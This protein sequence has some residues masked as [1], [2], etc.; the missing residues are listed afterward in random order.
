MKEKLHIYLRVSSRSQEVDGES[1]EFQKKLGIEKSTQLNMIPVIYNEGGKSSDSDDIS[2]RPQLQNLLNKIEQGEID[3]VWC[4]E[5]SRMFRTETV[6]YIILSIIKKHKVKLYV[7]DTEYDLNDPTLLFM[8][9]VMGSVN[10]LENDLRKERSRLGK[11][12][13]L[14]KGGWKGGSITFGYKVVDG[15]VEV[16]DKEKD[17]IRKIF[18]WYSKDKS[19][20]F[21]KSELDRSGIQTRYGKGQKNWTLG[22]IRKMLGN[23]MYRG[24]MKYYDKKEEKSYTFNYPSIIDEKT[25]N[26]VQSK[27]TR[28]QRSYRNQF[29]KTQNFY[30]LR[31][32]MFCQ[33]GNNM[34]GRI[35]RSKGN[36]VSV[37][38]CDIR[39]KV[40]KENELK[41]DDRYKRGLFCKNIR[42]MNIGMTDKVV[43]ENVIDVIRN[44]NLLK[45]EFKSSLVSTIQKNRDVGLEKIRLLRKNLKELD[46][47]IEDCNNKID[48]IDSSLVMG[49]GKYIVNGIEVRD[50]IGVR[51]KIEEEKNKFENMKNEKFKDIEEIENSKKWINWIEKF[52]KRYGDRVNFSNKDKK[53]IIENFV[54]RIEVSYDGDKKLHNIDL[55]FKLPV[56]DDKRIRN[57]DNVIEIVKGISRKKL[58][59]VSVINVGGRKKVGV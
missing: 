46:K 25:F 43:W 58:K 31:D 53:E 14:K 20:L 12:S 48:S 27:F 32:L 33:C 36:E 18:D 30:M 42:S 4:F 44:S 45:E 1:L 49:D 9:N 54:E 2:D 22:T 47:K 39:R 56:V 40:W 8:F 26:V 11:I 13:K 24:E 38:Y 37:Y 55:K 19:L 3:N 50:V 16:D 21:I 23:K 6:K 17:W 57:K 51:K 52:D 59:E 41:E 29:N 7:R 28:F 34:K 5:S 10:K 35:I 15:K